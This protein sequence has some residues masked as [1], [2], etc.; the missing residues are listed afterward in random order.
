MWLSC[1]HA[2]DILS[3]QGLDENDEERASE[4]YLLHYYAEA[5]EKHWATRIFICLL[6]TCF[7]ETSKN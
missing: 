7:L 5:M 1:Q 3:E 2:N 4:T 6:F